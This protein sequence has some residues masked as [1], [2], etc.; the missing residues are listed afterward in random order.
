MPKIKNENIVRDYI[1]I[2]G[3][4]VGFDLTLYNKSK[5]ISIPLDNFISFIVEEEISTPFQKGVIKLKNDNNRF[6]LLS[7]PN[8]NDKGDFTLA[9]TGE[10]LL[11]LNLDFQS[12]VK[13]YILFIIEE[14]TETQNNI[15]VKN[16]FVED[17][18]LYTLRNNKTVFSTSSLLKGDTTQ[19]SDKDRQINVSDAIKELI[20]DSLTVNLVNEDK[21]Y[22][23]NSKTNHTTNFNDSRLDGLSYLL[24][25]SVDQNDN[26]L[27]LLKRDNQFGLYSL[28]EMYNNYM[29]LNNV[30]NFG[31]NF[32]IIGEEYIRENINTVVSY[33]VNDYNLYNENSIDTIENI[34]NHK[35]INYDF[36]NKEFN[37]FSKDNT[38][39]SL[40]KNIR[41]N[42]LNKKT[43]IVREES[44]SV[45]NNKIFRSM[46]STTSDLNTAR[47][48][49][50]NNLLKNLMN[51]ST[52]L[53]MKTDGVYNINVGNF[54]NINY[55]TNYQNKTSKKLNGGWFVTAL[56]H[57]LT[58]N[59]FG[60]EIVCTKFHEL[61]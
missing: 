51:L 35:V 50:R 6:D 19:L 39:E 45:K 21:W 1:I 61:K 58:Q 28:Q 48:E 22:I 10:N 57:T 36:K 14:S 23:S 49:G 8:T 17:S 26:T 40:T 29:N 59:S 13:T 20:K 46:Y 12:T 33:K 16:F 5:S 44:P 60:S 25:K 47:F 24:D 11:I 43:D 37:I 34:I 52:M 31:G 55:E 30:D 15:K 42:F 2:D 54:I 32:T 27:L 18:S 4:R 7:V 38:V 41:E 56:K 3:E 53:S 9:E